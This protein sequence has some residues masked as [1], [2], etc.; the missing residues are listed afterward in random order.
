MST[1]FIWKWF[2]IITLILVIGATIYHVFTAEQPLDAYQKQPMPPLTLNTMDGGEITTAKWALESNGPKIINLFASWCTPCI[3]EL[4][5]LAE[6][7]K[8]LP[9]YGIAWKDNPENLREWL[10]KH[11]N[12]YKEIGIDRGLTFI[13]ELG[14]SGVP[15]SLLLDESQKIVYIHQGAITK[16]DIENKFLPILERIK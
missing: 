9:I 3:R 16:Q 15:V 13:W 7:S 4:P 6:L 8:H 12:P 5:V 10:A 1:G 2:K 11:G 14:V